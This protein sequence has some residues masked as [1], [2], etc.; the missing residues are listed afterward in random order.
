VDAYLNGVEMALLDGFLTE[1]EQAALVAV[2][3]EHGLSRGQV[4][5]IHTSYL[6]AL[7]EVAGLMVLSRRRSALT[8]SWWRGCWD[9]HRL[10]STRP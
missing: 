3:K 9:C 6:G 5:D 10:T 1:Q 7:A 2:A 8:W 4:M